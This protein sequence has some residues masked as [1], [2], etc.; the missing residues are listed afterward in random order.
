MISANG[1]RRLFNL[2]CLGLVAIAVASVTAASDA[3]AY[4]ARVRSACKGDYN[5]FCPGYK[6]ESSSLRACMRANGGGISKRCF[7][8]LVDAGE[9]SK[10]DIKRYRGQ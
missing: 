7:D 4:S 5:K 6:E 1:V 3:S 8:A 2:T 9:V 10:A